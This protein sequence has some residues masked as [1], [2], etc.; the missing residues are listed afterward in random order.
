M[1]KDINSAGTMKIM[2]KISAKVGLQ[3]S[4]LVE[5]TMNQ[6]KNSRLMCHRRVAI[7]ISQWRQISLIWFHRIASVVLM[8]DTTSSI[9]RSTKMAKVFSKL[10][11]LI[12]LI[13]LPTSRKVSTTQEA[14]LP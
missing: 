10:L 12:K 2:P 9:L 4:V 6:S 14:H 1:V 13:K 7:S 3:D 8:V 11:T 5:E